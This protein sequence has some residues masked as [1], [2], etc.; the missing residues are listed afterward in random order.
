MMTPPNFG[1]GAGSCL[2]LTVVVALDEPR[3]PVTCCAD[4]GPLADRAAR[5]NVKDRVERKLIDFICY[6]VTYICDI[7]RVES[8][9]YHPDAISLYQSAGIRP[10]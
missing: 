5:R 8:E 10:T 9:S 6:D 4:A 2:G 7:L 3:V 1:S